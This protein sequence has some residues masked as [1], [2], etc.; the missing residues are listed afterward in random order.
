MWHVVIAT[1]QSLLPDP[2]AVADRVRYLPT[3]AV[4]DAYKLAPW[5]QAIVACDHK[6]WEVNPEARRFAGEKWCANGTPAGD[7]KRISWGGAIGTHTNSGLLGLDYWVRRGKTAILLLGIDLW[8]THYFG[9]HTK[10][11][12][13]NTDAARFAVFVEQFRAYAKAMPAGVTVVNCSP[14]SRLDLFEKMTLADV[15]AERAAA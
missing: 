9:P 12:L 2:Q 7:V 3:V 6:W 4:S 8:G 15:L 5:A 11:K 14:N 10:P 1:G 13:R